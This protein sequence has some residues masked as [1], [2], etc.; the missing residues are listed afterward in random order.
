V[1]LIRQYH[2]ATGRELIEIPAG[3]LHGGE[4]PLGFALRELEEETAYRAAKMIE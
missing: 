3:T 2:H 1:I 4:D